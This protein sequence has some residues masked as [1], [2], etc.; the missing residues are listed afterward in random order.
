MSEACEEHCPAGNNRAGT[1]NGNGTVHAFPC[2]SCVGHGDDNQRVMNT[3]EKIMRQ[4]VN[5]KRLLSISSNL[6]QRFLVLAII[7]LSLSRRP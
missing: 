3:I 1:D 6:T 7:D 2:D 5:T 4:T